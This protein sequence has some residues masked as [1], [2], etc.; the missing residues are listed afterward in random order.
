MT[1]LKN[2]IKSSRKS[3]FRGNLS[4]TIV[5]PTL[6]EEIVLPR[7]IES[8][9]RLGVEI[10]ILDSAST[11][12]TSE[13]AKNLGCKVVTGNWSSFSEKMNYA[14]T[15]LPIHTEWIMRLDADE[16]LTEDFVVNIHQ[17]LNSVSQGVDAL[18]V[19]RRVI[20][21]NKWLKY[22]AMYPLEHAR[23][24]RKGK[25]HYESRLLDEHVIV[26][27]EQKRLLLDIVDND[28]KGIAHWLVKHVQYAKIQY[29]MEQKN[30]S[31]TKNSWKSLNGG[32]KWRRFIKEEIYSRAPM[33]FRPFAFWFYRY[34]LLFGFLDGKAGFIW[35][36]LHAFWYRFSVDALIYE[37]EIKRHRENTD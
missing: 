17:V 25:G 13:I 11:D 23:I 36:F 16:Y 18:I 30:V 21:L 20:F 24:T 35:H 7:A 37:G 8:C 4:L 14:L 3:D 29:L 28:Q 32:L 5:I 34:I 6:N 26:P 2:D 33:F 15:Q 1:L 19:R 9:K 12:R 22:G 31:E 10:F 27:G